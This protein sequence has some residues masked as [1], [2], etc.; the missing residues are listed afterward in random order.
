MS[1]FSEGLAVSNSAC[2]PCEDRDQKLSNLLKL[3]GNPGMCGNEAHKG[4]GRA[5]WWVTTKQRVAITLNPDATL[6][7]LSCS[8]ARDFKRNMLRAKR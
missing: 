8:V 2:R 5:I 3:I 4:C 6:H 1:N 7:K